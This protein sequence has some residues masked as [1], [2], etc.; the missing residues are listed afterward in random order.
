MSASGR[1]P[2]LKLTLIDPV[3][4]QIGIVGLAGEW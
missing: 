2:P 3:Q 1:A 4:G